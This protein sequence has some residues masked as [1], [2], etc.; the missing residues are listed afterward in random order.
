VYVV[1]GL[2]DSYINT[3]PRMLERL[4]CPRKG[5][6]GPW[7]H[8]WPQ[9]GDPGPRLDWAVE[10]TRWWDRWLN[11]NDNGI[12]DEPMLRGFIADVAVAQR[13]PADIPGRWV[14]EDRWPAPSITARR[15]H[16][17]PD[18]GLQASVPPRARVAV[19][20]ALTIG[21]CIPMLSPTDMSSMAPTE[22]SDDDKLS[23]VFDSEPLT[24]D[25]DIVGRS[26]L[27]LVFVADKPV[28][29]LAVR[30]NEVAADGRSWLLTYG[31]RNLAHNGDHTAWTP[32]V[33]GVEQTQ[34][35]LLNFTSRRVKKG[36]RLRLSVSQS[37]W[38]I[39]WPCPEAV[40]LQVVA[41]AT[42][43]D[44]PIRPAREREP[45][46]PVEVLSDTSGKKPTPVDPA[47]RMVTYDGPVGSRRATFSAA[48]PVEMRNYGA[49]AMRRGSG[50]SVEAAIN[51]GA[52]NSYRIT[53]TSE[54][55]SERE[56]W[57]AAAKV[58]TTMTS[59]PT[60]FIV[61]ERIE[62]WHNG[63]RIHEAHWTNR[64]RRDG[65]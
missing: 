44:I 22:Q 18:K 9:E 33:A 64:I 16:L 35:L 36:S 38:P 59:T 3:V 57:K 2:G 43:I 13:Y 62:A 29:K 15:L 46:M 65:N 11:G 56:G 27:R 47:M 1:G 12:M 30:L 37:Q 28:A 53:L 7:G 48:F 41:G 5:I 25:I 39:V 21:G 20:A 23:L 8:D 61:E 19:P 4:N 45:E 17:T 14:A 42:A 49:V 51:E 34:E 10:E 60:H 54:N 63:E 52:V 40:S 31:V 55:A 6:V 58:A 24:A 32:I 26:T 50:L